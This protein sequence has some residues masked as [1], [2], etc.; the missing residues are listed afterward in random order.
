M[1][2]GSQEDGENNAKSNVKNSKKKSEKKNNVKK[3][4]NERLWDLRMLGSHFKE[5]KC[6]LQKEKSVRI[7]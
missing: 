6:Y 5:K 1:A 2:H 3:I 7:L 4:I